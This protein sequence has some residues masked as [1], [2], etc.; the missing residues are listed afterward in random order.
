VLDCPSTKASDGYTDTTDVR[1]F[2]DVCERNL[3]SEFAMMIYSFFDSDLS[4]SLQRDNF[5]AKI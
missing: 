3:R 4:L 5:D 2:C 1:H